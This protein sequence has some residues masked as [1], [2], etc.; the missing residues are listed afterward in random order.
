[1]LGVKGTEKEKKLASQFIPKFISS[2]PELENEAIDAM[3]DLCEDDD[4]NVSILLI[5]DSVYKANHIFHADKEASRQRFGGYLQ[6]EQGHC[7]QDLVRP[8][9]APAVGRHLRDPAGAELAHPA[10]PVWSHR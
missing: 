7:P 9:P 4:V 8:S 2:F 6:G 1:M 5:L 3:F 10:L